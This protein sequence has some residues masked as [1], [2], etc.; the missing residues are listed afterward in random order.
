LPEL[1]ATIGVQCSVV[2]WSLGKALACATDDWSL[3]NA[4]VNRLAEGSVDNDV[5]EELSFGVALKSSC[6]T[7][8]VTY[9]FRSV[10]LRYR[11]ASM[12][13]ASRGV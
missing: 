13:V 3:H 10:S 8:G 4:A 6:A 9:F 11:R 1:S 7:S 5:L 12:E 2:G